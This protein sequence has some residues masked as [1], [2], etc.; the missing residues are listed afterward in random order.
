MGKDV[1]VGPDRPGEGV[2]P[3]LIG[4][5]RDVVELLVEGLDPEQTARFLGISRR[6]VETHRRLAFAKLGANKASAAAVIFLRAKLQR[7]ER[8]NALLR[9]QLAELGGTMAAERRNEERQRLG[10]GR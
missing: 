3:E 7:A 1:F 9:A 10:P 2:F 8:E 5:Q 4:R 6:T